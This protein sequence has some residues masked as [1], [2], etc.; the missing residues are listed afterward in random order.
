MILHVIVL[1]VGAGDQI[2]AAF[3]SL[4]DQQDRLGDV[5]QVLGP[6]DAKRAQEAGG[7]VKQLLDFFFLHGAGF[8][9]AIGRGELCFVELM[10]A[11]HEHD[12]GRGS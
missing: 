10:I 6:V 1:F 11:A 3:E 12:D 4:V 5:V 9:A 8:F 7:R 2:L